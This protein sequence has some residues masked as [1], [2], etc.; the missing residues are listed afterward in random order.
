MRAHEKGFPVRD[1][2]DQEDKAWRDAPVRHDPGTGATLC[3]LGFSYLSW[4]VVRLQEDGTWG[5][6]FGLSKAEMRRTTPCELP[7]GVSPPC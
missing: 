7:K 5:I 6:P 1:T 2:G 3:Y 4:T